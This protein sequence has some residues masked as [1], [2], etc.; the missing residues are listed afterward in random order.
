MRQD[1][2]TP[3]NVLF[4]G[5]LA[6]T[7]V[8]CLLRDTVNSL[9]VP[10]QT[11][12]GD[13]SCMYTYIYKSIH[14]NCQMCLYVP[15]SFALFLSTLAGNKRVNLDIMAATVATHKTIVQ[16]ISLA[17]P[18]RVST[19]LCTSASLLIL[20]GVSREAYGISNCA[21]IVLYHRKSNRPPLFY[22]ASHQLSPWLYSQIEI[23]NPPSTS[24]KTV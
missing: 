1:L 15:S 13:G 23:K 18:F 2:I 12:I 16:D 9:L 8:L 4:C 5:C 22:F 3:Y 20:H 17:S 14:H 21:S 7:L 24:A 19:P 11:C 6:Y 10:S